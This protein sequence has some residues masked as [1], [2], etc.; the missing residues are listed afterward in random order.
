M[1]QHFPQ[2]GPSLQLLSSTK[3][4][5]NRSWQL[6]CWLAMRPWLASALLGLIALL[7]Y[8][9]GQTNLPAIDRTEG[10]VA[11]SS[12]HVIESGDALRP[13]WGANVQRTRPVA[14]FW[15]QAVSLAAHDT[16]RWNDIA[17]YRLPSLL[18]TVF[19]V[20]LM[21][22]LGSRLVGPVP[23]LMAST[24]IAVTPIVA[25]HAQLAIAEALILPS[26]IVAQFALLAIYREAA[27]AR[28]WG[29]LGA[30]WVA[31]GISVNFNALAVP[32][33]ALVTVATLAILDRRWCFVR[34]LQPW[35]GLPLL[36][37]L[38]LPW[39]AAAAA[40]DDGSL[41]RG[42]GWRA[43]LDALEG[44][45]SMKFKTAYG[46]F[47]LMIVLGFVPIAHML[48][49]AA[50]RYWAVRH[51]PTVRLLLVWLIAPVIAL[52]I[53]SNKPPLY[54]V[55]AIFPAGALLVA[56]A[57]GRIEPFARDLRAWP[58]MFVGT[59]VLLVAIAPVLFWG[60]LWV[61]DTP[62]TP[63]LLAG[64]I[65]LAGL[66]IY[67]AW[68]SVHGYGMA[69]F[70]SAM[71]GT[72]ILGAWFNGL[73][74]PGLKNFWTA[75]QIAETAAALQRCTPGPVYVSGFREP[76]LALALAGRAE[77]GSPESAAAAVV[78]QANG[79][80]II[81]S[82]Q[83]DRFRKSVLQTPIRPPLRRLGCI[84]SFNLARGCSL[85]F[86]VFVRTYP[87]TQSGCNLA[88]PKDCQAG[89]ERLRTKLKIKHC[90]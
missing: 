48:G 43:V 5:D 23:A 75:P 3:N 82:R 77:I 86:E 8:L 39:L 56:L 7:T 90:G 21:F 37:V 68:V 80:A 4:L 88:L 2:G 15:A 66:F 38:A 49:P 46:V 52:E 45:Q 24:A 35:F 22:W 74:M 78:A 31:A 79:A 87:T 81:E 25:L 53:F 19:A 85:L 36:V 69:W 27:A 62:L 89:H 9:P 57:V 26:I 50:S 55:Q 59:T 73:L 54:T 30:F 33:L 17:V 34:R 12:R 51:D 11:L 28:W 20:L 63:L 32:L 10:M 67:A 6:W 42:M 18:A 84:R 47:V 44:G 65:A 70:S 16:E 40:V 76:S 29:W 60:I 13:R 61:T 64:F 1:S 71:L 58:G 14:T 83:I 72:F 41:Y